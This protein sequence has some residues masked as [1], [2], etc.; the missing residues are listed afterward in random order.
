M[1]AVMNTV[2]RGAVKKSKQRISDLRSFEPVH[3]EYAVDWVK[4]MEKNFNTQKDWEGSMRAMLLT[5]FQDELKANFSK[6]SD[7]RAEILFNSVVRPQLKTVEGTTESE[8]KT[9][10]DTAG[11]I[12]LKVIDGVVAGQ[13]AV[14][15]AADITYEDG[16]GGSDDEALIVDRP[17]PAKRANTVL[18]NGYTTIKVSDLWNKNSSMGE[19]IRDAIISDFSEKEQQTPSNHIETLTLEMNKNGWK[20][21]VQ[22]AKKMLETYKQ[23][24]PDW[25]K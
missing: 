1:F 6:M 21:T 23:E 5:T 24:N 11:G 14:Q 18:D 25:F 4:K 15:D 22:E 16:V 3:Q 7:E 13:E 17:I 19:R 10:V 20:I 8:L 12:G 2:S 9:V